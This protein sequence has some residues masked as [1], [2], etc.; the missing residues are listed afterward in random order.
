M[1]PI[2]YS[3]TWQYNG[4]AKWIE[5]I[6]WCMFNIDGHYDHN[7]ADTISFTD[8]EAYTLFLLRWN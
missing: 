6:V 8:D 1:Q 4:A 3:W 2:R 7:G 5:I